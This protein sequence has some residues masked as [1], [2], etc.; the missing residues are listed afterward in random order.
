MESAEILGVRVDNVTMAAAVETLAGYVGGPRLFQVATVNPEFI[1]TARR[2]PEFR[3]VL[4]E[5]DLNLPDGANLVRAARWLGYPL[6][7][8]V[9]G[10]DLVWLLVERAARC[11]WKVFFLGGQEGIA[12]A[13]ARRLSEAYPGL[14]VAGTWAGSPDPREAPALVRRVNDSGAD[15]LL[16]AYG[17]PAQ[18]L[19]IA[20][21]R[22]RLQAHV[23]MGVGGAFDFISGQVPRAPQWMQ[24]AGFEWLY[25]L[26]RQPWRW[27]RQAGLGLFVWLVVVERVRGLKKQVR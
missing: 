21:N 8:R 18:D 13:A 4:A 5:T 25:R 9:G 23:A 22:T 12:A 17:A 14:R 16:V 1:L 10:S 20:N 15:I 6:A 2:N 19:W 3:R 7:E 24:Q 27:R 26:V 11:G